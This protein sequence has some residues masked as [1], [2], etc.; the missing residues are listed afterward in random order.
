MKSI[1]TGSGGDKLYISAGAKLA[2]IDSNGGGDTIVLTPSAALKTVNSGDGDDVVTLQSG[3]GLRTGGLAINLGDGDDRYVAAQN[4]GGNNTKTTVTGGA[5][6]DALGMTDG[7]FSTVVNTANKSIY[8][9]F[10]ILDVTGG[11]GTYDMGV[12]G[13]R[14]VQSKATSSDVTLDKTAS[15]TTV[16][17]DGVAGTG[18][19]LGHNHLHSRGCDRQV[20]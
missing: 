12:L 7:S 1:T 20:R 16:T 11:S 4:A 13:L 3:G 10:E 2:S 5:G 14:R 6:T 18:Y 19:H 9:D 8:T 17:V 15:G